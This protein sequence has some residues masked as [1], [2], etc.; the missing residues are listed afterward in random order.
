MNLDDGILG[1][2][3]ENHIM[4]MHKTQKQDVIISRSFDR[5]AIFYLKINETKRNRILD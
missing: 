5:I 4:A 1:P 2:L 3:S